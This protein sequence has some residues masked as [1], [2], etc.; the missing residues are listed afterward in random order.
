VL[1]WKLTVTA[2]STW[3]ALDFNEF[4]YM[5]NGIVSVTRDP[6]TKAYSISDQPV[7]SAM[8][9]YNGQVFIGAPGVTS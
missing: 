2:G 3:R 1:E 8:C 9:S 5:S 7:A 6:L 4:V